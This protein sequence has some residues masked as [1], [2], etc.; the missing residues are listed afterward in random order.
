MG[1]TDCRWWDVLCRSGWLSMIMQKKRIAIGVECPQQQ[2]DDC[3]MVWKSLSSVL[4]MYVWMIWCAV[5]HFHPNLSCT[6][7]AES[8]LLNSHNYPTVHG[9]LRTTAPQSV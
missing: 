5:C 6:A 4:C 7:F 2:L 8:R 1:K 3:K 9:T